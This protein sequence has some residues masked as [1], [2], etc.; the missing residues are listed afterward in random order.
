MCAISLYITVLLKKWIIYF[1]LHILYSIF[2]WTS[3]FV[4]V[5]LWLSCFIN[6]FR[7]ITLGNG[8]IFN[9]KN[10]LDVWN[11]NYSLVFWNP[12]RTLAKRTIG[13]AG[14]EC[15]LWTET[16]FLHFPSFFFLFIEVK[17]RTSKA[18]QGFFTTYFRISHAS[19]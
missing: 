2:N 12:Q 4:C 3:F 10:T 14:E 18:R 16:F 6:T 17:W 9:H 11:L 13:L 1:F 7:K 19:Q 8:H 15:V 5:H